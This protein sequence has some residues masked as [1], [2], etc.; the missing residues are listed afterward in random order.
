MI[1]G[2]YGKRQFYHPI[3]DK[4]AIQ[5]SFPDYRNTLFWKPD[6]ITNANGEAIIEFYCSDIPTLF[7]GVIEGVGGNGLIGAK[8]FNFKVKKR[9]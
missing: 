8:N 2:Y 1:K 7:L 4:E 6:I 9:L 5:D 3:Y